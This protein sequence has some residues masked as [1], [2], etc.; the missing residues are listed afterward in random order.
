MPIKVAIKPLALLCALFALNLT[1]CDDSSVNST[2]S[3]VVPEVQVTTLAAQSLP[4]TAELPGRILAYRIAEVRPQVSGII[5]QRLF[6]EGSDVVI[7]QPLYQIDSAPLRAEFDRTVAALAQTRANAQLAQATLARYRTL[8]GAQYVSRQDF[9]QAEATAAQTRAAAEAARAAEETARI[10]LGRT[11]ITSPLNGRIGRSSVTEG[12][13]VQDQQSDALATVQQLDPLYLDVTQSSQEFLRLQQELTSGR[14]QRQPGIVPVSVILS[15]GSLYPHPGTLAFSDLTVDQTTGAITL[16]AIVPNPD[17]QL[18]PGMFVRARI[19]L[20]SDPQG[21]TVPQQAVSRTP[22]GEATALVVD[23]D[24]R[25][26]VRHI[27]VSTASSDRWAV[28][29]GLKPGERAIVSGLQR[30]QPGMKVSPVDIA[31]TP[32]GGAN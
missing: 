24:N 31:A 28:T 20:G 11:T 30:A 29:S 21:L 18:L 27:T 19:N 25:V 3:T 16:R 4:V 10:N 1:G 14:L 22:R 17:R 2:Q 13:L 26:E 6:T 12:A 15:D 7:G 23:Q 9:D 8:I 32:T 5:L